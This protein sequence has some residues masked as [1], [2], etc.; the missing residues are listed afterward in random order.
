MRLGLNPAACGA[1]REHARTATKGTIIGVF[2]DPTDSERFMVRHLDPASAPPE[3]QQAVAR[4]VVGPDEVRVIVV[5]VDGAV[6][7]FAVPRG[8]L[9]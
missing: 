3:I 8:A 5:S 7:T 6:D 4:T 9:S 2:R 1:I